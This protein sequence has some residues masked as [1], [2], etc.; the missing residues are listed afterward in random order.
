[1][2]E[3]KRGRGRKKPNAW[4]SRAGIT[5]WNPDRADTEATVGEGLGCIPRR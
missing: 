3:K 2:W 4:G 5:T 1:M